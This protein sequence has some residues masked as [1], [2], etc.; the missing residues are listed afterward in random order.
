MDSDRDFGP[1]MTNNEVSRVLRVS[2]VWR[3]SRVWIEEFRGFVVLVSRIFEGLEGFAG[4][5]GGFRRFKG[6]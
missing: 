2:M 3:V 5:E 1:K 6:F 4:L